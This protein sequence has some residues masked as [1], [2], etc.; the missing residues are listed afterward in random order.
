MP[1]RVPF[2]DDYAAEYRAE[3]RRHLLFQCG[4]DPL[5][6]RFLY[7]PNLAYAE[8]PKRVSIGG[9]AGSELKFLCREREVAQGAL[10]AAQFQRA[11]AKFVTG[12]TG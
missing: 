11:R 7:L 5:T 3:T 9:R 8:E 10:T 1:V 2:S 4:T 6:S 12:R